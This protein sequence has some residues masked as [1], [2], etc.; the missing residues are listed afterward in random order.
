MRI[1]IIDDNSLLADA[2]SFGL[3]DRGHEVTLAKNGEEGIAAVQGCDHDVVVVDWQMPGM[4]GDEAAARIRALRPDIAIV[5]MS[6]GSARDD[7]EALYKRGGAA[8]HFIEKP[9][10]PTQLLSVIRQ[11]LNKAD[12]AE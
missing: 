4:R 2:I 9:F 3:Q 7:I 8:N 11:A 6:G 5:L 1:C 12:A 10:T